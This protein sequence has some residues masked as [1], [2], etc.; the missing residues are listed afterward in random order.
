[1]KNKYGRKT[2]CHTGTEWK[3]L[4]DGR[5]AVMLHDFREIRLKPMGA[6]IF[7]R[8][9]GKTPVSR[10]IKDLARKYPQAST[11]EIVDEANRFLDDMESLGALV[12]NWD[13]F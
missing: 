10:I 1:L 6:D 13:P 11:S 4:P 2:P 9:N 3:R 7:A 5:L 12:I 8:C